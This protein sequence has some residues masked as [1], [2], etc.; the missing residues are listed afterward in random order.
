MERMNRLMIIGT[1]LVVIGVLGFAIPVFTTQ[2]TQDV[3][4]IGDIKLQTIQDR[5]YRIPPILS[6][7]ALVL[8][9]LLLGMGVYK[10]G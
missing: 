5:S 8:G 7:G 9:V 3:A 2:K 10:R 6:G 4:S 1:I